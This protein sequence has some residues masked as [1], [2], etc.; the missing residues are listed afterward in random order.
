[1]NYRCRRDEALNSLP[2]VEWCWG[3]C[4]WDKE[5]SGHFVRFHDV[6]VNV[7]FVIWVVI[8]VAKYLKWHF[9]LKGE[10]VKSAIVH[11]RP[12]C[13]LSHQCHG[14]GFSILC[15]RMISDIEF[16]AWIL[17]SCFEKREVWSWN[18]ILCQQRHVV[19]SPE[20]RRRRCYFISN[21]SVLLL[22]VRYFVT[23][24]VK[25][26]DVIICYTCAYSNRIWKD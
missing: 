12:L 14:Y 18:M 21:T 9:L 6:G 4:Q 10:I 15:S 17:V 7:R 1:M 3:V 13:P 16:T 20:I 22:A 25:K 8:K 5:S 19:R 23:R 26:E 24:F 2:T 11:C